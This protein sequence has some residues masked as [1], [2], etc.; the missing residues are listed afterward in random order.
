MT[1]LRSTDQPRSKAADVRKLWQAGLSVRE[2]S[3]VL[4]ISTQ[5][6]HYHLDK[7]GLKDKK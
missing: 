1:S 5:G 7:L 3:R 2:I 6:V 4:D